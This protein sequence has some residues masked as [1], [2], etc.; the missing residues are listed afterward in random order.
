MHWLASSLVLLPIRPFAMIGHVHPPKIWPPLIL[1]LMALSIVNARADDPWIS[2]FDG[3]TLAGWTVKAVPSDRHQVWWRVVDGAIEANSMDRGHH[4]YIWLY[5][6]AEYQDFVLRLKFQAFRHNPGNSG[7]QIRSRYDDA[8]GPGWLNGPQI[9]IH[10]PEPWRTGMVW[11]ETR[12]N[13][14]W[15]HPPVP[16]G[17]WVNQSMAVPEL[18]F[19]YADDT[20]AWNDF[21]ITAIGPRLKAVLNGLT[22]MEYD[23]EGVLDD[24][25]HQ[26]RRVGLDGHIA[27]Q[28]HAGDQ[29]RIRYKD[30]FIR[31]SPPPNP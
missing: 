12:G 2:L 15:L 9:D 29:L 17:H 11:D 3:R 26:A 7:V 13:Q 19:F 23:G 30:I 8:D 6:D 14:R 31:H 18:K 21:E 4:D 25:N 22:I 27:L 10:P 20:P 28:I 24:P 1:W 16:P 5:S